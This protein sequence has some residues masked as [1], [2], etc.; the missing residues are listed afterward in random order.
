[1]Q[2]MLSLLCLVA[3]LPAAIGAYCERQTVEA[4]VSRP[5]D[6]RGY[7]RGKKGTYCLMLQ[8]EPQHRFVMDCS[9]PGRFFETKRT[10]YCPYNQLR[11]YY[12]NPNDITDYYYFCGVHKNL[13][14]K[15]YGNQFRVEFTNWEV[16]YYY[17][18]IYCD[19]RVERFTGTGGPAQTTPKSTKTA[20]KMVQ[21]RW[22]L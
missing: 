22:P 5:L 7:Q 8:T 14:L 1:M 12:I 11:F 10:P 13:V 3:L 16:N 6:L 15:T 4:G 9:R 17:R 2:G 21:F 19:I 18:G 20:A